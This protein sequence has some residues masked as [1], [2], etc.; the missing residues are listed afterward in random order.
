MEK[1]QTAI[2]VEIVFQ[3][4]KVLVPAGGMGWIGEWSIESIE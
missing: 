3:W 4:I 1:N 2:V